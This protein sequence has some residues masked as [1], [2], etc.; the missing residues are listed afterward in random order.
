LL[1][2]VVISWPC[3]GWYLIVLEDVVCMKEE[4]YYIL[5]GDLSVR[6]YPRGIG[7]VLMEDHMVFVVS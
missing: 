3:W 7:H 6:G 5:W 2:T 4:L 1:L